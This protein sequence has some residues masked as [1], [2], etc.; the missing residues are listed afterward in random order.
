MLAAASSAG[1]TKYRRVGWVRWDGSAITLFRVKNNRYLLEAP[2]ALATDA[3]LSAGTTT[4]SATA[5]PH[6]TVGLFGVMLERNSGGT[7]N[8]Y[9]LML[10]H[11]GSTVSQSSFNLAV[12]GSLSSGVLEYA[13]ASNSN[14]VFVALSGNSVLT[15][16]QMG[17]IDDRSNLLNVR[18]D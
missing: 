11:G 15:L 1:Y 13:F 7:G 17:W 18:I 2:I 6:N 4:Y 16:N 8:R 14:S 3:A 12:S 5:L 10:D 9:L